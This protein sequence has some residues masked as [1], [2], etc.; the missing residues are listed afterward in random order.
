MPYFPHTRF[1]RV[2]HEWS[3]AINFG[4][5]FTK[6]LSPSAVNLILRVLA[7]EKLAVDFRIADTFHMD[8]EVSFKKVQR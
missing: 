3:N 8:T 4:L 1:I 7:D 6:C 5:S 2:V